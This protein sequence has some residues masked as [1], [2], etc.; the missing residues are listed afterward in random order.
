MYIL[1]IKQKLKA[2]LLVPLL[3]TNKH[4]KMIQVQGLMGIPAVSA[5]QE[6]CD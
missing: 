2:Y 3:W 1:I 6:H 4:N 5:F